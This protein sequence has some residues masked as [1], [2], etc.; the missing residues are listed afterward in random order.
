MNN[1]FKILL[2]ITMMI[3]KRKFFIDAFNGV[4]QQH[5]LIHHAY[6]CLHHSVAMCINCF[7][8]HVESCGCMF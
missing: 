6:K 3:I 2:V 5:V 4:Y 7:T 8:F 1:K